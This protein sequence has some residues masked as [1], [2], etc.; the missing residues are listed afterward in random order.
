MISATCRRMPR[1][2][3]SM[4]SGGLTGS[5]TPWS[6]SP[7]KGGHRHALR[8]TATAARF[9]RPPASRTGT[10]MRSVARATRR[11]ARARKPW[12]ASDCGVSP[13]SGAASPRRSAINQER[14]SLL[15][16]MRSVISECVTWL[17]A[18]QTAGEIQA[19]WMNAAMSEP[20][21]MAQNE[22][23]ASVVQNFNLETVRGLTVS[24]RWDA[25]PL[26]RGVAG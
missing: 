9:T 12:P 23:T 17:E 19:S 15:R 6:S 10:G 1:L 5:V 20:H 13:A 18:M 11:L 22:T 25:A 8:A 7:P 3:A 16:P 14:N 4:T 24:A 2:A 21:T 26:G